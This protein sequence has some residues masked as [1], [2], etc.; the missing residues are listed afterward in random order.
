MKK[1]LFVL[2]IISFFVLT[3]C[4]SKDDSLDEIRRLANENIKSRQELMVL[5]SENA[6]LKAENKSLQKNLEFYMLSTEQQYYEISKSHNEM[7]NRISETAKFKDLI[8]IY[9]S[10][11]QGENEENYGALIYSRIQNEGMEKFI[12]LLIEENIDKIDG[13]TKSLVNYSIKNQRKESLNNIV[14]DYENNK[15]IEPNSKESYI[16]LRLHKLLLSKEE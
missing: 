14:I 10:A 1:V 2:S 5:K 9:I 15:Q 3:S 7:I 12:T 11:L 16:I 6:K 13:I 4:T 8:K